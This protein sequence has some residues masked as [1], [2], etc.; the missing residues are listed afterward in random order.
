MPTTNTEWW[1]IIATLLSPL[2]AVQVQ[3]F[4]ERATERRSAQKR[5][6][7]T[8]MGTRA[9]RLDPGHVQALDLE[10]S[11]SGWRKQSSKEKEVIAK[12]RIYADHLNQAIEDGNQARIEAWV[13]RGND[14]FTDLLD[15]LA[16]C[17]GYSFDRV[18]LQR[19]IYRPRAHNELEIRQDLILRA[20]VDV[21]AGARP[22]SMR[23]VEFPASEELIDLQK[24][25][26]EGLLNLVDG[27][28]VKVKNVDG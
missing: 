26:Q 1:I 21:L 22:L 17:L 24:R 16:S 3:K 19:G 6:F 12:W 13:T 23:V 28:A 4:I 8:L 25:L 20:A 18:Q 2:I 7:Y 11:G 5:I 27:G 15:A 10:F 9:T 14:L